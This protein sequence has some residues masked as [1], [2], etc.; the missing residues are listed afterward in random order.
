MILDLIGTVLLVAFFIQGYRKGIIVAIFS[1][2]AIVLGVVCALKLSGKFAGYLFAQG[3]VTSGWAQIVSYILLFVGVAWVVRLGGKFL[4][5]TFEAVMLGLPNRLIGGAIY[6]IMAAIIWSI[7]LWLGNQIHLFTP[8]T[9]VASKTY[10]WFMPV[11]PWVFDHVG[12]ILPF[13][14]DIFA[15]LQHFFE[16][17]NQQLPDHVGAH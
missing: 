7:C 17:V 15:E 4:Q 1:L 9:I 14:K 6:G 3:W 2:L 5:K 12:A 13:A 8:E 11:A 16:G 10:S